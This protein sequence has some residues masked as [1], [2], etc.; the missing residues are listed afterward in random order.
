MPLTENQKE[1]IGQFVPIFKQYLAAAERLD[2]LEVRRERINFYGELLSPQGIQSMTE[3]EFGQVISSLWAF[4]MWGN[5]GYLVEKLLQD[6]PLENFKG[7]IHSLLWGEGPI[8][9][10]YNDFKTNTRGFGPSSIT[11]LLAFTHPLD[12]GLWNAKA[13]SA[14]RIL[15]FEETFP[16]LNGQQFDGWKYDEF[17][18]LLK[19]IQSELQQYALGEFDLLGIDYFL[20]EVWRGNEEGHTVDAEVGVTIQQEAM[21]DFDHDEAIEQLLTIGQWL[22]FEVEKEK[23]VARGA[24]VDVIWQARVANLGV[25]T[26]VFEVQRRGD[27]DSLILNLQRAQNNPTVQRLIVVALESELTRVKAEI[28]TLRE[29]FRRMV[30][31]LEVA[32]LIRAFDLVTELSGI[33]SKL[34]LVKSEFGGLM[35]E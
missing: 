10:R 18:H 6:N 4:A 35:G 3:L 32:E 31:Y 20:F 11:E 33:I 8:A 26:Y 23:A 5:Q 21:T 29:D 28:A 2:D 22:G 19:D 17:N 27:I 24:R 7:L 34:E 12:Y 1:K 14:L 30:G 9:A 13:R 25:V 15:G 16:Y